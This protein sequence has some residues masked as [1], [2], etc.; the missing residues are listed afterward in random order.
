MNVL[1]RQ[2]AP[3]AIIMCSEHEDLTDCLWAIYSAYINSRGS[4][5]QRPHGG[6]RRK[7]G[8]DNV[9]AEVHSTQLNRRLC[10][11]ANNPINTQPSRRRDF[12]ATSNQT[13]WTPIQSD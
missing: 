13:D 8:L 3:T 2:D 7:G 6:V 10:I 11:R 5:K 12:Y 9:E 4:H 1:Q